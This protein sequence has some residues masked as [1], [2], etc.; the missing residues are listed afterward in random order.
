MTNPHP[1]QQQLHN[2]LTA[3]MIRPLI[4][5][6]CNPTEEPTRRHL[7]L[8]IAHQASPDACL[9]ALTGLATSAIDALSRD[10]QQPS[11]F[12]LENWTRSSEHQNQP[13]TSMGGKA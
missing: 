4:A 1:D 10:R 7:A 2:E 9:A 3:T 11:H 8:Q 13:Q 6:A 5:I 12:F